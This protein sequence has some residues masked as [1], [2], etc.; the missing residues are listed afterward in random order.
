MYIVTH[1][2][3]KASI[4]LEFWSL[5]WMLVSGLH[6]HALPLNHICFVTTHLQL[7]AKLRMRG[8]VRPLHHTYIEWSLLKHQE[9]SYFTVIIIMSP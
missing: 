3:E 4:I 7:V 1:R 2:V 6:P 8:V 9:Q 5:V